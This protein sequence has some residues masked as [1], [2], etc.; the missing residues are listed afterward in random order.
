MSRGTAVRQLE[1]PQG[2]SDTVRARH[3]VDITWKFSPVPQ[4]RGLAHAHTHATGI[5]RALDCTN[6][7]MVPSGDLLGIAKECVVRLTQELRD[8]MHAI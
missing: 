4:A 7:A 5:V 1:C 8:P 3:R 2:V 6:L